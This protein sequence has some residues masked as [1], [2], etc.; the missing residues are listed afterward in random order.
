M[1]E[2]KKIR[3]SPSKLK[4]LESCSYLYHVTYQ[5]DFP[6]ST[7]SGSSKGSVVHYVLECLIDLKKKKRKEYVDQILNLN[8]VYCV[9]SVERL[10][11]H[12]AKKLGVFNKVDLDLINTFILV[13]L[14]N[15]F[16]CQDSKDVLIEHTFSIEGEKYQLIGFI[17]KLAEYEDKVVVVDYKTSKAK[18]TAKELEFDYQN[19]VYTMAAKEKFPHLPVSLKFLFLKFTTKPE[20][21]APP[22]T[23][24]QIKGFK[25]Y[26]EYIA[27]Y[28]EDYTFEKAVSNLAKNSVEKMWQCGKGCNDV[29]KDGS[30]AWVCHAKYPKIYFALM[31]EKDKFVLSS[32]DKKEL[33]K[34]LKPGYKIER[35]SHSGC[36]GFKH[37]WEAK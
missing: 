8:Y 6:R 13:A 35:R 29:K 32:F 21:H 28:L 27:D 24:E 1:E 16:F 9:P 3:L 5:T 23:E 2:K 4:T 17:D 10:I 18:K 36:P 31:N 26:L 22:V 33:E 25:E 34:K 15:D 37:L 20:Q 11:H 14:K 7:N 19:I 30:S 12:H